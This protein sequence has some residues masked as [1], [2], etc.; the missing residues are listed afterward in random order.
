MGILGRVSAYFGTVESQGRAALHLHLL[1]WLMH[2]PSAEQMQQLLQGADFRDRIVQYIRANLRAYVPG[3]ESKASIKAL[4]TIH[5]VART[6]PVHPNAMDYSA[7]VQQLEL[8]LARSEQLHT[9]R[10]VRCLI[11]NKQGQLNVKE[12]PLS[13]VQKQTS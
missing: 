1:L 2:T 5:D 4:P 8:D 11:W 7:K 9:C 12:E 13:S 10:E 6:R 3:L